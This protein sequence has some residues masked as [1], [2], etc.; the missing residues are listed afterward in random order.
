VSGGGGGGFFPAW[1]RSEAS[2]IADVE[3]E[4]IS[5]KAAEHDYGVFANWKSKT[6]DRIATDQRRAELRQQSHA[7][8]KTT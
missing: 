3:N 4:L 7:K 1:E 5:A 8:S 2:V 6:V